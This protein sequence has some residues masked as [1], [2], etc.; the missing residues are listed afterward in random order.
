MPRRIRR[1]GDMSGQGRA[2]GRNKR[3]G[4]DNARPTVVH[5]SDVRRH[6]WP[7]TPADADYLAAVHGLAAER[8]D[9][10]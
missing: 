9:L 3:V 1:S 6:D 7:L 4:G 10:W 5:P 2:A 8:R